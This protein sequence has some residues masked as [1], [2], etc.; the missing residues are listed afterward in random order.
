ME[1]DSIKEEAHRGPI[2]WMAGH[3]VAANLLMAVLLIGGLLLASQIKKEVF[4]DFELDI[5]TIT[6]PYPGASPEEVERGII[7]AIEEAIEGLEGIKEFTA[8]AQEGVGTV[9]VEILEGENI[10]RLAQDIKNEVDRITS[11]PEEAEESQVVIAQR[12]RYVIE[13][14]LYG[15]QN[16]WIL[17]EVAED[18]RDRL[19]QLGRGPDGCRHAADLQPDTGGDCRSHSPRIGG[20]ARRGHQDRKRGHPGAHEG[21]TGLRRPIRQ[22]SDNHHQ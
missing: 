20:I 13:L 15:N 17:R 12:K 14:A 5:V 22:N 6:V 11:F 1:T 3:S 19:I 21:A 18:I 16:E 9:S 2:A 8:S 4:P 10:Q 7:L